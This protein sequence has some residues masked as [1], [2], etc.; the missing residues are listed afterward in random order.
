MSQSP[1][2]PTRIIDCDVHCN[3][4]FESPEGLRP[5]IPESY[6]TAMEL[7]MG[8]RPGHGYSHPNGRV[9]R[10]DCDYRSVE[11]FERDHIDRYGITYAVMQPQPTMDFSLIHNIDIATMLCR[12]GNDW[13]VDHYLNR[14]PR[15]LGSICVNMN[16]PAGAVREIERLGDHPQ[17][18]QI[19]APGE[20]SFLYGH[21]FYHPIYEACARKHL[22]FALHPGA[23]GSL[24]SS[25]SVGRPSSYF[26]WHCSLPQTFMAHT[27][28]LVAE[29]VFE[30]FPGL[31]VL[32]TEGGYGWLAPLM[33][34]MDK[35]FKALRATVPWLREAPS[36][37]IRRHVKLTTQPIEEPSDPAHA[38]M[39]MEM[40]DAANT[41]CFS[42]DYPHWDFDDPFRAFPSRTPPDLLERILWGN[43]CDLYRHKLEPLERARAADPASL[44]GTSVVS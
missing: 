2:S 36:S 7:S 10:P 12:A 25:T 6:R 15:Y 3:P 28:S 11:G 34:R 19:L 44:P 43:A 42:S 13:L 1:K 31:S 18:V 20:A 9:Q 30:K 17:M 21:R 38:I 26:E 14:S 16:D 22:V 23:E 41:L 29:G 35:N 37:Y 33:W 5:Y 24:N 39:M 4:N 27:G 8:T 32:L 40:I